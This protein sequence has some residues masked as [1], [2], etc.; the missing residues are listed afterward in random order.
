MFTGIISDIGRIVDITDEEGRR[1]TVETRLPLAEIPIGSS[2]ATSG[3]CFTMVE[4]RDR[5][6]T[7]EASGATLEV[8]TA[9]D[10]LIGDEVNLERSLRVGDE[11]GGHLVFGHVDAVGEIAALEPAGESH[12]LEVRIPE[13]LAPLIA[14]KGSIA[15]DG[16]SLTVNE[17]S[18]GGFAVNII[19]HT[20]RHTNLPRRGLGER[21]NVEI[22]MLARYVA[23]QL[24][25]R[26][27]A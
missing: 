20:L 24:A 5:W 23:R 14:V 19:P 17:V 7:V 6:F 26:S 13:S 18:S 15:V 22:D 21:V 2:V 4:K 3:I 10:W 16:M 1:L 9:G 27:G 25:F 12:R 11:M 8:T